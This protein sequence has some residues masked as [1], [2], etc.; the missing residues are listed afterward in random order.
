MTNKVV[1]IF[2][3]Y[4]IIKRIV[5]PFD[6]WDA[7]D[8]GIIDKD[9][10]VL[11]KRETL[12]TTAELEAWGYFDIFIANLKK[13]LAKLPGGSAVL[14]S[15]VV[16]AILLREH[17]GD[18]MD[19]S[20]LDLILKKLQEE[21]A[22]NNAGAGHIAAIGVGVDGEPGKSKK[23]RIQIFKKIIKRKNENVKRA[24]SD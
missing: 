23:N 24:A 22:V 5:L 15:V 17:E 7:Y 8:L 10:K 20:E 3:I 1:D 13:L 21:V 14:T 19:D 2:L 18:K 11:R 4:Q 12:K 9:G 6:K 16:S